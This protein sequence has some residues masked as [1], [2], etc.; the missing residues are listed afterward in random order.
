MTP[1]CLKAILFAGAVVVLLSGAARAD[2]TSSRGDRGGEG[3]TPF[4]GLVQWPEATLFTGGLSMSVPIEVPS[5]RKAMTPQLALQYSNSG[6]P[7]PYGHGWDLPLGRIQRSTKWGV[8]TCSNHPTDFVLAG[9][10]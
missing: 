5:G 2:T 4:T 3:S 6:G 8:P 1:R 9:L 7:S 10:S